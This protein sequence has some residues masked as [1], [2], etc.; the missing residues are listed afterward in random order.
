MKSARLVI[1][2]LVVFGCNVG[3]P[4]AA[5]SDD[6][7][8]AVLI[9]SWVS[10]PDSATDENTIPARQ[11]FHEDGT[12]TLYIYDSP[13]CRIP[14]AEFQ[15]KW[16]VVNG[17]LITQVTGSSHPALVPPGQVEQVAIVDAAPDRIVLNSDGTLFVRE[18]SE[19]CYAPGAHR[20]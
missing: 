18:K 15:A 8:R 4:A 12:T 9:G 1:V 3:T 2:L 16:A 7:L 13:E 19:I 20:T 6:D 17:M 5:A 10:P 11:V 14:T